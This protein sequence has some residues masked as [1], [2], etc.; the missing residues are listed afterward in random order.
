MATRKDVAKLA[1]VSTATVSNVMAGSKFVSDDLKE[2]VTKA[3]EALNY[4]PS[5]AAQMLN[6]KRSN[7]LAILVSDI[8]NPYY[9][10]IAA[11]M[12]ESTTLHNYILS[13]CTSE[14]NADNYINLL[15]GQNLAGIFLAITN[16]TLEKKIVQKFVR[17][18]IPIVCG[19]AKKAVSSTEFSTMEVD[20]DQAISKLMRYLYDL[21]H[22]KVAYLVGLPADAH[23]TRLVSF[24]EKREE[25][26]FCTDDTLLFYGHFPY[27]TDFG[28]GYQD[29]KRLLQERDDLTAVVCI[30]DLMA[31][32]AMKAIREK[33][34]RIPEDISVVGCD[35]II[36]S[37]S[38]SPSLTTINVPKKE[39]GRRVAQQLFGEIETGIKTMDSVI[40]EL[41]IRD[42]TGPVKQ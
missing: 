42:S 7:Q 36:F 10:E 8:S 13:I 37:E 34:L 27:R 5:N 26:G 19:Q 38:V 22:R 21:G 15:L 4:I 20:Y 23:D 29:M 39:L 6:T 3:I 25:L 24:K 17:Y 35:N 18:N 28:S 32:G 31:L 1:G 14:G 41:I 11:G 16:E 30:N 40:C 33:G 2:K 9:G 12:E